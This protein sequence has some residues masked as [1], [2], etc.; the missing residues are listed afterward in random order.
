[1]GS[2]HF[3]HFGDRYDDPSLL[4][5][6]ARPGK[7]IVIGLFAGL[8]TWLV[9]Y[10]VG[11]ELAANVARPMGQ[12]DGGYW[13]ST[14]LWVAPLIALAVT[15]VT[16]PLGIFVNQRLPRHAPPDTDETPR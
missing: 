5:P 4:D 10:I 6:P 9:L 3:D 1:M 8:F 16:I 11:V 12:L 2:T 13:G 14:W 15:A 7:P